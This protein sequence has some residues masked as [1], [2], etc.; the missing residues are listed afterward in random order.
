MVPCDPSREL[1]HLADEI[2]VELS[3]GRDARGAA[4]PRR[5]SQFADRKTTS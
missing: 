4:G 2:E 5:P 3:L 1:S